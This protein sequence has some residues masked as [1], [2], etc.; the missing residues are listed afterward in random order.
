MKM[1]CYFT[2]LCVVGLIGLCAPAE[3]VQLTYRVIPPGSSESG[4]FG[5]TFCDL[6]SRAPDNM[7][8]LPKFN[9]AKPLFGRVFGDR[10]LVLDKSSAEG[11]VWDTL[12]L[13][14]K[15][16][17]KLGPKD[18]FAFKPNGRGASGRSVT[19]PVEFPG[20]DGP[21]LEHFEFS[22]YASDQ[23]PERLYVTSVGYYYGTATFGDKSHRIALVDNNATGRFND[24]AK[25]N[26]DG[27][28]ILIDFNNEGRFDAYDSKEVAWVGKCLYVDGKYWDTKVAPDGSSI[29]ITPSQ[30]PTGKLQ[31]NEADLTITVAGENGRFRLTRSRADEPFLLPIGAYRLDSTVIARKDERGQLWVLRGSRQ[32]G[33]E[34]TFEI[35]PDATAQINVGAPLTAAVT[36]SPSIFFVTTTGPAGSTTKSVADAGR[37]A[38]SLNLTGSDGLS[39]LIYLGRDGMQQPP[40]PQLQLKSKDGRIAKVFTFAYG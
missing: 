1:L 7:Q 5:G 36:V 25:N 39:Y 6:E 27:H 15:G 38:F 4:S 30:A 9:A 29:T 20:D 11:K 19:V 13:D 12:W 40:A 23:A 17:G 28:L 35:K 8:G 26:Q 14:C 31:A 37:K 32:S 33:K 3:E 34:T 24:V 18:Q 21:S 22:Y 16:D 10:L 2:S